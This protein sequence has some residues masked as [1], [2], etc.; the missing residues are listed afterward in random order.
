MPPT[1]RSVTRASKYVYSEMPKINSENINTGIVANIEVTIAVEMNIPA[2]ISTSAWYS[3]VAISSIGF[4]S[5]YLPK[6]E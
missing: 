5:R 2:V 3:I 1:T 6:L 4:S